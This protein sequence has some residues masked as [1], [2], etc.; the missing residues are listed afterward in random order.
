L[1][2]PY[3]AEDGDTRRLG[4][5]STSIM[6][7]GDMKVCLGESTRG[8]DRELRELLYI[9]VTEIMMVVRIESIV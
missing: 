8:A 9:A 5:V 4:S 3:Q 1:F 6:P 7:V 2:D